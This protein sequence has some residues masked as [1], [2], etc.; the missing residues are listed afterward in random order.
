MQFSFR[1]PHFWHPQNFAKTL[2]WH[3]VTLFAFSKIPK[4]TIKMGGKTVKKKLGPVIN[5]R[6]GPVFNARNPKSW[7]SFELYS[8]YIYAVQLKTGPR[9]G[10]FKVKN[11]SKLKVKNWSKFFFH[12]FPPFLQC[13]GVFLKTQ[14]VSHFARIVFF[15]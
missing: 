1:K 13:F 14:I 5:T 4:N 8:I 2:F 9:F 6:L 10:G 7:T 3:S 11:W 12:C 15:F